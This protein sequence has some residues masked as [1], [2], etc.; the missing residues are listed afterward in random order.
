MIQRCVF[1]VCEYVRADR[2]TIQSGKRCVVLNECATMTT[3][4]PFFVLRTQQHMYT[5]ILSTIPLVERC[6]SHDQIQCSQLLARFQTFSIGNITS[7]AFELN[8]CS[9]WFRRHHRFGTQFNSEYSMCVC[10]RVIF[11]LVIYLR[12]F[13]RPFSGL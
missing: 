11:F 13:Q 12:K 1:F 4:L 8:G 9:S 10:V 6:F 3:I 2:R 7:V 5:Y